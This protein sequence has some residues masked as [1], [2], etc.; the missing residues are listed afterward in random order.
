MKQELVMRALGSMMSDT[1]EDCWCAGWLDGTEDM[2]PQLCRQAVRTGQPQQWGQGLITPRRA[3]MMIELAE[4]L[5][6]WV[7]WHDF[8]PDFGDVYIPHVPKLESGEGR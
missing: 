4:E 8:D 3:Q 7:K 5:G 1:S 2:L 6:H